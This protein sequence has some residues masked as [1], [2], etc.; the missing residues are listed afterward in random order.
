[1]RLT[2][3][4]TLAA[5]GHDPATPRLDATVDAPVAIAM[6]AWGNNGVFEGPTNA[7]ANQLVVGADGSLAV[8]GG[9]AGS[10]F[11]IVFDPA[12]TP[13]AI[14]TST[15]AVEW[16]AITAR[17]NGGYYVAGTASNGTGVFEALDATGAVDTTGCK[18][19]GDA[20]RAVAVRETSAGITAVARA[21]TTNTSADLEIRRYTATCAVDGM[22]GTNGV[23]QQTIQSADTQP[24]ALM[25]A[26]PI[27]FIEPD[28]SV[29]FTAVAPDNALI[30]SVFDGTTSGM[31]SPEFGSLGQQSASIGLDGVVTSSATVLMRI[32]ENLP[33]YLAA[34][35]WRSDGNA[36]AIVA[37]SAVAV[38]DSAELRWV[39]GSD[40]GGPINLVARSRTTNLDLAKLEVDQTA[41]FATVMARGDGSLFAAGVLNNQLV[42]SCYAPP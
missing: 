20:L 41:G 26:P 2:A 1:M 22:F 17:P 6:C 18:I 33:Q 7:T 27:G 11:A 42:V 10:A 32:D 29:V 24:R 12:G 36:S 39:V 37:P 38:A 40:L 19:A 34:L 21:T 25:A 15:D 8:V 14:E 35:I 3:L 28:R 30:V 23:E 13:G 9:M 16:N 4:L 31:S 5:C